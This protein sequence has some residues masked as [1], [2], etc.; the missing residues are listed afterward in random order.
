ML[1]GDTGPAFAFA[2][3]PRD[4]AVESRDQRLKMELKAMPME[5]SQILA[6]AMLLDPKD[7]EALAEELLTTVDQDDSQVLDAVWDAEIERRLA[8][9]DQGL[10]RSS[11][12]DQMF[13]RL[14]EKYAK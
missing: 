5:K 11:P 1:D 9:Y 12:P 3:V 2:S 4:A 8:N 14:R 6:E 10:T 13:R 7:R